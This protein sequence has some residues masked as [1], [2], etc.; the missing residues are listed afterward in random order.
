MILDYISKEDKQHFDYLVKILSQI[1]IPFDIDKKLVRGLDYYTNTTFEII[2]SDLG[3]QNALCGGGRYNGLIEQLGGKS[4][5]K[6]K[7][8][9]CTN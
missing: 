8:S 6:T 9:I 4:T 5:Q 1:N 7:E 3:A 2:S